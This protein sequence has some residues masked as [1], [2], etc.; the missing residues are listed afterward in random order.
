M[1]ALPGKEIE[2]ERVDNIIM[3]PPFT[4][5]ET[6]A[7][8]SANYKDELERRFT[9]AN[10]KGIIDRRMSFC[11]YFLLLADKFLAREGRIAA[12][13]PATELRGETE[14]RLREYL[15]NNYQINYII[16]RE[17]N[18][19]FSEST[20]FR[21]ILFIITKKDENKH[22]S[23]PYVIIKDLENLSISHL[24][25]VTRNFKGRIHKD[26]Y[27]ELRKIE[28]GN[29]DPRNMFRQI[30]L[31]DYDLI[32][33][34]DEL[35]KNTIMDTLES[36]NPDILRGPEHRYQGGRYSQMSLLASEERLLKKGDLWKI[37]KNKNEILKAKHKHT[38]TIL[39]IPKSSTYPNLRRISG[40]EKFDVSGLNEFIV[41]SD[42]S[43][44]RKFLDLGNISEAQFT[45]KWK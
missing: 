16:V 14:F 15:L 44:S 5:Q 13:L 34:W 10:E 6:I 35:S 38:N 11:S 32:E 39:N 31:S 37:E 7:D 36:L 9:R 18:P 8:F 1:D 45:P 40:V 3:N 30:S 4:R 22:K 28:Q 42:F 20:D 33:L 19:N 17:D 27:F 26:T 23:I 25:K 21:E 41:H 24:R 12:V 43:G 2:F 29:I